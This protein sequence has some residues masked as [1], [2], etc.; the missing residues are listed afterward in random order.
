MR[1]G[2]GDEPASFCR[3]TIVAA[4][5][6]VRRTSRARAAYRMGRGAAPVRVRQCLN[7]ELVLIDLARPL[8]PIASGHAAPLDDKGERVLDGMAQCPHTLLTASGGQG[9]AR[10]ATCRAHTEASRGA[11]APSAPHVVSSAL[12]Q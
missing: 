8:P 9:T 7:T 4:G 12:L 2:A 3:D 10:R 5:E 1:Q 6:S 11:T